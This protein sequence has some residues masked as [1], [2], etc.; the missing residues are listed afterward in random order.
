MA[1]NSE[2]GGSTEWAGGVELP[3]GADIPGVAK[4][5]REDETPGGPTPAEGRPG[6]DGLGQ[7]G[8]DENPPTAQ[9]NRMQ[10]ADGGDGKP[11]GGQQI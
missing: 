9:E 6:E 5:P 11:M 8:G 10:G 7:G 1:G 2:G 3:Q 4:D